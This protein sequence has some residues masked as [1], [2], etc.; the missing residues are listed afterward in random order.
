MATQTGI[1]SDLTD[2]EKTSTFQLLDGQL[3]STI[4]YALLYGI[5]TGILAV[6]LWNIFINK[7]WPIRRALVVFIILLHVLTTLDFAANWSWAR[8]AFIENGQSFW[9][10][11]LI[12]QSTDA[13]TWI[14]DIVASISTI[15]A[16][17]HMIWCCWM[18]WGRRWLVVL[19]PIFSLVSA[20]VS[21]TMREYYNRTNAFAVAD[22]FLMLYISFN[23][24]TTLSCTLLIIYRI[25]AVAGIRRGAVGRLGVFRRFIEVLVESSALYS[26]SLILV[27]AFI[28]RDDFGVVDFD[29][30]AGIA[31]GIAPTLLVGRAAAGHTRPREDSDGSTVS[32]LHFQTSSEPSTTSSQREESTVQSSVLA[33]DIEAQPERQVVFVEEDTMVS[34]TR[35]VGIVG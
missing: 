15:L 31:K 20:I 21:R 35:Q 8:F 6:T 28:I 17:S 23:L 9:T 26:I 25:V 4:L 18:V 16:D 13:A 34:M 30:I 2:N 1:P 5:Y 7:C 14:M 19:L 33:M 11:Y 27:L 32:S 22:I 24:A 12:L 3:N 29:I 10:V